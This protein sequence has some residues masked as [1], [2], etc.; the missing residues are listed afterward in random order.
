[1]REIRKR[2]PVNRHTFEEMVL[3]GLP[4]YRTSPGGRWILDEALLLPWELERSKQCRRDLRKEREIKRERMVSS[5]PALVPG[6]SAPRSL[7]P[8]PRVLGESVG[9][10]GAGDLGETSELRA[11]EPFI[12]P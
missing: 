11:P 3:Q 6:E 10:E 2:L 4:A 8:I 9:K 7:A 5:P 12:G 1:M